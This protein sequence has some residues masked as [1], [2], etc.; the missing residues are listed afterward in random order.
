VEHGTDAKQANDANQTPLF[1]ATARGHTEVADLLRLESSAGGDDAGFMGLTADVVQR[2]TVQK[3]GYEMRTLSSSG[4]ATLG[5]HGEHKP[6]GSTTSTD[7]E[8]GRD[9]LSTLSAGSGSSGYSSSDEEESQ[10]DEQ[11]EH[12]GRHSGEHGGYI[13]EQGWQ[14]EAEVSQEAGQKEKLV[15]DANTV[16]NYGL[17]TEDTSVMAGTAG[18]VH[19]DEESRA[20]SRLSL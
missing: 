15:A 11:T 2:L 18:T 20:L 4:G 14:V 8:A 10:I 12:E 16:D 7:V 1:I 9:G 3:L 5:G 13:E 6:V 19:T 17:S